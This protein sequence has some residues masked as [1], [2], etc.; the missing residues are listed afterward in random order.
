VLQHA[1]AF[2]Q[3]RRMSSIMAMSKMPYERE[4][5]NRCVVCAEE[6]PVNAFHPEPRV[7][8]GITATCR[9]CTLAR[10]KRYREANPDKIDASRKKYVAKHPE[11]VLAARKY[12]DRRAMLERKER[13]LS[14]NKPLLEPRVTDDGRLCSLCRRRKPSEDFPFVNGAR[15]KVHCYCR[16][17]TN[18][19]AR[20]QRAKPEV[21]AYRQKYMRNLTL[22]QYGLTVESFDAMVVVQD[23]RCAVCS[24]ELKFG[25]G[26]CAVDHD[27]NTGLVRGI[28]CKLCNVGI[29]HFR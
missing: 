17:C 24:E 2:N 28:L 19:K 27:H 7:K 15:T 12:V 11:R 18:R 14:D 13:R 4:G 29:G 8:S 1:S 26:G 23:G 16:D 5:F 22:R 6:K 10:N 21:N 3:K 25:T 9:V 20:E